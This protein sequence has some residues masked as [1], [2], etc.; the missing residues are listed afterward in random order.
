MEMHIATLSDLDAAFDDLE[1]LRGEMQR[2]DTAG[3]GAR[4]L[5]AVGGGYHG[6]RGWGKV[7]GVGAEV[8]SGGEGDG[9]A[10]RRSVAPR[11][12]AES[13]RVHPAETQT[14][15]RRETPKA[16]AESGRQRRESRRR[17]ERRSR[18]PCP[19][20]KTVPTPLGRLEE[21]G[22]ARRAAAAGRQR[23]P[24]ARSNSARREPG[25]AGER[26][27][28]GN[29]R[30]RGWWVR[31]RGVSGRRRAARRHIRKKKS[32]RVSTF[33]TRGHSSIWLDLLRGRCSSLW[34]RHSCVLGHRRPL[35][36]RATSR[37]RAP[38][39][40]WRS[41]VETEKK[42]GDGESAPPAHGPAGDG[43]LRPGSGHRLAQAGTAWTALHRGTR[44]GAGTRRRHHRGRR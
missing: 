43:A 3:R 23:A 34:T 26:Q 32:P 18:R 13:D 42:D 19:A 25:V 8:R 37:R 35:L 6:G 28:G 11:A 5:R 9:G 12:K 38:P 16:V 31:G 1:E 40:R 30:T 4:P 7:R 44:S 22:A 29:V 24:R 14:R 2:L 41:V 15:G 17:Q 33:G 36:H 39:P 21:K 27:G 10:E 20:P